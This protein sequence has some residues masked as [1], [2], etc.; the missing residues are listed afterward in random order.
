LELHALNGIS[1]PLTL[2]QV[3][4]VGHVTINNLDAISCQISQALGPS[5]IKGQVET[6]LLDKLTHCMAR[7]LAGGAQYKDLSHDV[8]PSLTI[9]TIGELL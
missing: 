7:Y 4:G 6:F 2:S 1:F 9:S 8:S 3:V 5:Q